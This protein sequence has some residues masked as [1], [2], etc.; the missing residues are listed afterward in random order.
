MRQLNVSVDAAKDYI[1]NRIKELDLGYKAE[2]DG[3]RLYSE[4]KRTNLLIRLADIENT[5]L[6]ICSDVVTATYHYKDD[7]YIQVERGFG[8]Q[9]LYLFKFGDDVK[10]QILLLENQPEA[11]DV[12]LFN[13]VIDQIDVMIAQLEAIDAK[14]D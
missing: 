8:L 7:Y 4:D 6:D 9:M 10:T 14:Y 1:E 11:T 13:M 3:I 2:G 12:D 5:D